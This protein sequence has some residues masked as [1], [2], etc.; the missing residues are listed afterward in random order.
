M[1]LASGVGL[2]E[3]YVF[4]WVRNAFIGLLGRVVWILGL[5]LMSTTFWKGVLSSPRDEGIKLSHEMA[6]FSK[7]KTTILPQPL[8]PFSSLPYT[9]KDGVPQHP[10][11]K[12][13]HHHLYFFA[14]F[15]LRTYFTSISYGYGLLDHNCEVKAS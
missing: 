2:I 4:Q 9:R 10:K 13:H 14:I 5:E 3:V 11:K 8:I 7:T 6:G 1:E 15:H 12:K